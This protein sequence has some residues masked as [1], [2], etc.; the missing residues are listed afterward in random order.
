MSKQVN[1]VIASGSESRTYRVIADADEARILDVISKAI[2]L[3]CALLDAGYQI[4]KEA[5]DGL[6]T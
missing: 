3:G 5:H 4:T 1:I 2:E 6:E